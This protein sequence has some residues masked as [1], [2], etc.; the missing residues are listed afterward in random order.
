MTAPVDSIM[1]KFT[2][3]LVPPYRYAA[4]DVAGLSYSELVPLVRA[5]TSRLR[6]PADV[7]AS[8]RAC[9]HMLPERFSEALRASWRQGWADGQRSLAEQ[10][11]GD[12]ASPACSAH[13][14]W[15]PRQST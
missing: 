14:C 2:G 6:A 7:M 5:A 8:F 1:R 15:P 12:A 13:Q 9:A 4:A 3:R 10:I 11:V